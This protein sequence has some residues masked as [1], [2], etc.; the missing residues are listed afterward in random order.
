MAMPGFKRF[1]RRRLSLDKQD[2]RSRPPAPFLP[3]GLMRLMALGGAGSFT[4]FDRRGNLS[5]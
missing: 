3:A 5:V 1:D 2:D 4:G